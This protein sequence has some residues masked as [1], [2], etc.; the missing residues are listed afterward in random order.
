VVLSALLFALNVAAQQAESPL[1]LTKDE[2]VYFTIH[3]NP[4]RG[5]YAMDGWYGFRS[6]D[7]KIEDLLRPWTA[8]LRNGKAFPG[9]TRDGKT[10]DVDIT[11]I[12]LPPEQLGAQ[13]LTTGADDALVWSSR[14]VHLRRLDLVPAVLSPIDQQI[15]QHEALARA[16]ELRVDAER[17]GEVKPDPP[18]VLD[19]TKPG[20]LRVSSFTPLRESSIVLVKAELFVD[21]G[22]P[23]GQK[24][25]LDDTI[26]LLY[27]KNTQSIA[28]RLTIASPDYWLFQ[29]DGDPHVYMIYAAGCYECD[30][31]TIM[32]IGAV[33]PRQRG[34][35]VAVFDGKNGMSV[36]T[37]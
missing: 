24:Q 33:N 17:P 8:A 37:Y 1:P 7:E 34:D 9:L 4:F 36:W 23:G 35:D 30:G 26:L 29:I 32:A 3:G 2:R 20:N 15:I 28:G 27:S 18:R 5:Y 21:P 16:V 13:A 6:T 19:P 10:S 11:R 31:T 22:R 12:D 25:P 14:K